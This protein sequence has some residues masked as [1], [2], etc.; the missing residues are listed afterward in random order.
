MPTVSKNKGN[1]GLL[2]VNIGVII[3]KELENACLYRVGVTRSY[4]VVLHRKGT[5]SI[6]FVMLITYR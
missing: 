6:I 3:M 1:K 5:V 2:R 4:R